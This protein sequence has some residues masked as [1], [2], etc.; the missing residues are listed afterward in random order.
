[1]SNINKEELQGRKDAHTLKIIEGKKD[2]NRRYKDVRIY[3]RL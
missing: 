1:M 3:K 2:Y